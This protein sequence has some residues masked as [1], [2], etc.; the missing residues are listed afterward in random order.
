MKKLIF[1]ISLIFV[2]FTMT[3]S[4]VI[5][6]PEVNNKS[7]QAGEKL[8]YRVTYGF[9]DAGEAVLEVKKTPKKYGNREMLQIGRASCRERV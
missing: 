8:R 9:V 3:S 6:Y 7:F 4:S 5:L 1:G 2:A